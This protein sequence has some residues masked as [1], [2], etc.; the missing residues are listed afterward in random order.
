[1]TPA[2]DPKQVLCRFL[3]DFCFFWVREWSKD[4]PGTRTIIFL[5]SIP[6]IVDSRPISIQFWHFRLSPIFCISARQRL[7]TPVRQRLL[8][9][10]Q[11]E[12]LCLQET[13]C[14]SSATR[15]SVRI[16]HISTL[17]NS[18]GTGTRKIGRVQPKS[19]TQKF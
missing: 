10:P 1:M 7:C 16:L 5:V 6:H 9:S 13:D 15:N 12:F 19:F 11:Q 14:C 8:C 4:T 17:A 2:R 18:L 3:F